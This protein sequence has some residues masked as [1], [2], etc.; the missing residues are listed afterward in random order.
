MMGDRTS[1][2]FVE[3]LVGVVGRGHVI[4]DAE[5]KASYETDW[6]G[7]FTGSASVVVRPG[8]ARQVAEVLRACNEAGVAVVAQGGNTGLVGGSIPRD[9]AVLL[10]LTRLNELG[11]V[12][13]ISGQVTVGAGVTLARLQEHARATGFDFGV[14]I[15]ARDSA[16]VGG[17][18]ATNA[19]GTRVL[20]YGH[21]R[22]Q[23]VGIEAVLA[24]GS[25][26]SRMSGLLKD[27][28]GYDLAGL[29][30]GSE[31]TLGVVTAARL[32]L[33]S[34]LNEKVTALLGVGDLGAALR[35]VARLR[36]EVASLDSVEV[37][38]QPG[39]ELVMERMRLPA[40]FRKQHGCY[41]LVE[42][43]G[44]RDPLDELA[45]VLGTADEVGDS[46]LATDG[47]GRARLWA[48][49]EQ[50][51]TSINAAGVPHKL[52]VSLPLERMVS[53][54]E[55]VTGEVEK[56]IPG[57]TVILFGHAADGNLH[58]NVLGPEPEDERV[59]EVVFGLVA[60]H[61]GSISAE[62]GIGVAKA[63]WLELTRS[64]ADIEAMRAIKRALDPKGILN[65]G[66]IFRKSP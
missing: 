33:V 60:E 20:R 58:V 57:S 42:C 3:Q 53:F 50:H 21:M 1:S 12:D 48:Y 15:A 49:R 46:A 31:G 37:F 62:H 22:A 35:I 5:V 27:N 64:A 38:F 39:L 14:D 28:S 8:D 43:A 18:I 23:V 45:G 52:D 29:L 7:R 59:S 13:E 66:V 32:R 55:R 17:M 65:P 51:T 24:D 54:A 25:L 10:S 4:T 11:A 41:L 19:G 63:P 30:V 44:R 26:I 56:A 16:T 47:P 34:L 9:G 36:A 61:G 40:P 2:P 6:T